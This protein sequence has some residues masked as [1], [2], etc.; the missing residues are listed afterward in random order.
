MT[1]DCSCQNPAAFGEGTASGYPGLPLVSPAAP[2]HPGAVSSE[3]PG[4]QPLLLYPRRLPALP[5]GSLFWHLLHPHSVF[6]TQQ[7]SLRKESRSER[8]TW[9]RPPVSTLKAPRHPSAW[10]PTAPCLLGSSQA[11]RDQNCTLEPWSCCSLALNVVLQETCMKTG[12][13]PRTRR[14]FATFEVASVSETGAGSP[15]R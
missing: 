14:H 5:H 7:Q 9:I 10:L 8:V 6:S 12:T 13:E 4:Q 1:Q 15:W 3:G 11:T 2:A